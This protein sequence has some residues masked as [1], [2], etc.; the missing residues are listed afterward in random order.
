M[1]L[2]ANEQFIEF[3]EYKYNC[4]TDIPEQYDE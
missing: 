1:P 4:L 3:H 2:T